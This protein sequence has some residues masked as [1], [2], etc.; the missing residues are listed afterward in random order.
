M[1]ERLLSREWRAP[2][3]WQ[4]Q[5][6]SAPETLSPAG[7]P[8]AS[9]A[10]GDFAGCSCAAAAAAAAA[11]VEGWSAGAGSMLGPAAEQAR[12]TAALAAPLVAGLA[13]GVPTSG[14]PP[15]LPEPWLACGAALP[16]PL[17]AASWKPQ[18]AA[19]TCSLSYRRC[20]P[21]TAAASSGVFCAES[22]S[23]GREGE[24]FGSVAQR[25]VHQLT[26]R[27]SAGV[28]T[29]ASAAALRGVSEHHAGC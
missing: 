1:D 6:Q 27:A 12:L 7:A 15:P 24:R 13:P 19:G 17:P 16:L 9:A 20:A 23:G 2:L 26:T 18:R 14:V 21:A 4:K 10:V 5:L 28:D 29:A 8:A 22:C 3:L 11:T 25:G